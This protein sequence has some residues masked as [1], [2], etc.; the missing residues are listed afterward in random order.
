MQEKSLVITPNK[1]LSKHLQKEFYVNNIEK[2]QETLVQKDILPLTTWLANLWM[3]SPD[4]RILLTSIQEKLIWQKIISKEMGGDFIS[5]CDFAINFHELT[6]SWQLKNLETS[7]S[8][9]DKSDHI[10][11]Q[12][13]YK[14]FKNYCENKNLVSLC[15]LP[16]LLLP[17]ISSH[18]LAKV[19]FAG[20]DEQSPQM[21]IF[22]NKL[23]EAGCKVNNFDPNKI[24]SPTLRRL[25]FNNQKEEIEICAKWC[26]EIS[27]NHPEKSIGIVVQNLVEIRPQ[28]SQIFNEIFD[29]NQNVNISAGTPTKSIPIIKDALEILSLDLPLFIENL[30]NTLLS[31]YI[32]DAKTNCSERFILKNKLQSLENNQITLENISPITED[33]ILID[34][35]QKWQET[36]LEIKNKKLKLSEWTKEF[37]KI[38]QIFGWPGENALT[39]KESTAV[40]IFNKILQESTSLD[41]TFNEITHKKALKTLKAIITETSQPDPKP[42]SKINITGPLEAAGINFDYLWVMGI[43]Q[44]SWPKPPHPNPFIPISIQKKLLMP[45][46][47]AERELFFCKTLIERYKRSAKEIIFSHVNSID[48]RNVEPSPLISDIP[49]TPIENLQ[50]PQDKLWINKIYKSKKVEE[51]TDNKGPNLGSNEIKHGTSRLVE[52]QS[53]C[54]FRAFVEFRLKTK[55]KI[56]KEHGISK[57]NR[58]IIIHEA[59]ENL[60]KKTKTQEKLKSLEN[61]ELQALIQTNIKN[62]L[63]KLSLSKELY[64]LEKKFLTSLLCEWIELEKERPTFKVTSTEKS[65][66]LELSSISIKLRIDRIDQTSDDKNLLIDYKTGKTLPSIFDW[67]GERPKNPQIPLYFL[68]LKSLEGLAL[69]QIN[70]NKVGMKEF[71]LENLAVGLHNTHPEK[72]FENL[73]W[74]KL[75]K[76]WEDILTRI[77]DDFISGEATPKPQSPVICNQ[78]GFK[79]ICRM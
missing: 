35:L 44:E 37:I 33:E 40:N 12:K 25:S 72:N 69:A 29:G 6:N 75:A 9:S 60:W 65:A 17:Y 7:K 62:S 48:D 15:E 16:T 73:T 34:T 39:K 49:E 61:T 74:D 18:N 3:S 30:E 52:Q 4:P 51:I 55:E 42:D 31:P 79:S 11:F 76:Y 1:R 24:K 70:K 28:T 45:H 57:I 27:K 66:N 64:D 32:T 22:I 47:S 41:K 2:N 20:F 77:V 67:F 26:K 46:S 21:D 56:K 63:D 10:I 13:I 19:T 53:L 43:D 23:K 54:P 59:L 68:A 36:H 50:L 8:T 58:G 14:E 71:N 38:L 78:C 5:I